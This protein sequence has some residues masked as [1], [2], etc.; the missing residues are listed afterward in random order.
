M[1]SEA[2]P[3]GHFSRVLGMWLCDW[4]KAETWSVG[5]WVSSWRFG[6][7]SRTE[8]PLHLFPS[9]FQPWVI[10]LACLW[11]H[12]ASSDTGL[13]WAVR[14]SPALMVARTEKWLNLKLCVDTAISDNNCLFCLSI[15]ANCLG[16]NALNPS[17]KPAKPCVSGFTLCSWGPSH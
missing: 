3:H 13:T 2:A 16:W 15:S 14:I 5:Y 12:V 9:A 10:P 4:S 8:W 6:Q 17:V 1:A 7:N 11:R